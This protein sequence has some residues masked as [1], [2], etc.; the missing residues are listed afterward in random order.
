MSRVKRL[1]RKFFLVCWR[2]RSKLPVPE[3]LTW[4]ETYDL[5]SKSLRITAGHAY[6]LLYPV[7]YGAESGT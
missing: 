4:G 2:R 6:G 7:I 1:D 3:V 5:G